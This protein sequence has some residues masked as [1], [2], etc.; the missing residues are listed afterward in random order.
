MVRPCSS[1]FNHF[2]SDRLRE[3]NVQQSM[4]MQ[5]ADLPLINTKLGAAEAVDMRCHA[6]PGQDFG[7]KHVHRPCPLGMPHQRMC[8]QKTVEYLGQDIHTAYGREMLSKPGQ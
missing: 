6:R 3:Q 1:C 7:L 4:T 2:V 8:Q 5:V